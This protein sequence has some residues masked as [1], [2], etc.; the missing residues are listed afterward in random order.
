MVLFVQLIPKI[1]K[2]DMAAERAKFEAAANIEVE[3]YHK[4]KKRVSILC[5]QYGFFPVFTGDCAGHHFGKDRN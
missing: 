5:R 3:D 2:T 4:T 1:L